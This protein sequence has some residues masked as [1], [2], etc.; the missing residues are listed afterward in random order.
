MTRQSPVGRWCE[1]IIEAG[2]LL[3]LTIVPIYF[4][5]FS[6]RHFEPDKA[7]VLR[8]LVLIMA[9]A[10]LIRGLDALNTRD[11]TAPA[12]GAPGPSLWQ[13]FVRAPLAVPTMVYALVFVLTTLTSVVPATSFWGSYQRL[14]GAYTNLSYIL[15]FVLIV[16]TIRRRDQIERIVTISILAGLATAGY[17]LLQH[18]QLDPLP[19]RGDVITRV[20]STMGNSIFVAAYMIMLVPLVL[21]RGVTAIGAAGSAPRA[22]APQTVWLWMLAQFLLIAGGMLLLL[23]VIKFGAAVR[24]ADFRYWWVFPGA[25]TAATGLWWMVTRNAPRADGRAPIWPGG[26]YLSFLLVF[27]IQFSLS[28]A[29]QRLATADTAPTAVD[30]WIWLLVSLA[31]TSVGYALHVLLPRLSGPPTMLERRVGAAAALVALMMLS[32]AIFFTQS[33]GPWIGLGAG[34]FVFIS[35]LIWLNLRRARAAGVTAQIGRLRIAL[36]SWIGLALALGAFLITFNLSQAPFFVQ[37]RDVPYI[38][39]L[40]RLLEIDQGTGLVRRLIWA[41]DEHAGG[42]VALITADPLRTLIGWGPESMFVAFNPFYPPTLATVEARGASPDRAHQALLDELATKGV[43]GLASYLFLIGSAVTLCWRQLIRSDDWAWQIFFAACLSTITAHFVEGLTG[44]PIVST[45]MFLWVT[46]AVAVSGSRM[47]QMQMA[48]VETPAEPPAETA[49]ATQPHADRKSRAKRS[50]NRGA[51]RARSAP[52][53]RSARPQTSPAFLA[54]YALVLAVAGGAAW[55]F[56]LSPVYADMRFQAAQSLS[57]RPDVTIDGLVQAADGYLAT[58]RSN[59]RE[60]FYYLNLGRTL[61]N[62]ADTLRQQGVDLGQAAPDPSVD[63]LL[64]LETPEALV[65]FL[66]RNPPLALMSYAE[67]VLLRAHNL[68]ELNKDHYANLGR[69]NNYWYRWSDD[70]ER[71]RIS[72]QWYADVA[73][74]A[75]QDVTLIN[76]HAGVLGQLGDYARA[77]DDQAQAEQYYA[78]AEQL[79]LHSRE[80]DPSYG[81]TVLRLGDLALRMGSDLD[82]AATYYL[83]AIAEDPLRTASAVESLVVT[84]AERPELLLQMRDAYLA[85]AGQVDEQIAAAES[86]PEQS[87][88]IAG[89]RQ[90]AASLYTV[91]GLLAVRG[92]D[93]ASA[94]EPYRLAVQYFPANVSY[95]RNYTIV[96][97]DTGRL[98]A[99]IS[100]TE[101]LIGEL[102]AAGRDEEIAQA[103]QVIAILNAIRE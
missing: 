66:Q 32:G 76:E 49:V 102:Q 86:A 46:L 77:H 15:L 50:G 35:L 61:M 53:R 39:R 37:L 19:W 44:I 40:G 27:A 90:R 22:T 87:A 33:R 14:Q 58:I 4:N 70:I 65:A 30:W 18:F 67:V 79:L 42:A 101:R 45:L 55:W 56:N 60:D 6:A 100:E 3:A 16:V 21:Y 97:S 85:Q 83:D 64:G 38:G 13:R 36:W 63:T 48:A 75:P 8:S 9:A 59:P 24:T 23:A 72:E 43:L 93:V 88:D 7:M 103:R 99:A 81:N 28:A 12:E 51:P 92:G 2:W 94:V 20:A 47:V 73:E 17:G 1:R 26:L 52:V 57:E 29:M 96:L 95:S 91:A 98:D 82:Q 68:N 31:V 71:L 89:L 78:E 34:I 69:L 54:T 62:I 25:V 84:F 41:G 74:I 80:L 11:N 10:G 5:L